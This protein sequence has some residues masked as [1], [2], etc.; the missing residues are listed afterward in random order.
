MKRDEVTVEW[1]KLHNEELRDLYSYRRSR[2]MF[3]NYPIPFR[4][5][6]R[7]YVAHS[8]HCPDWR[9]AHTCCARIPPPTPLLLQ[10]RAHCLH[11]LSPWFQFV[12]SGIDCASLLLIRFYFLKLADIVING[13]VGFSE[14]CLLILTGNAMCATFQQQFLRSIPNL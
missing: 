14:I 9:T 10:C 13:A 2:S 7:S 1:R 12:R 8:S 3:L 4:A 5:E 11:Q 6:C